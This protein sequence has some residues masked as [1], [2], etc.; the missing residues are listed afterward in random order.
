MHSLI[1]AKK[2][3]LFFFLFLFTIPLKAQVVINEV[4]V[5][6]GGPQGMLGTNDQTGWYYGAEYIEIFNNSCQPIDISG[7]ILANNVQPLIGNRSGGSFS[8]PNGTIIQPNSHLVLGTRNSSGDPNS[9]DFKT[10]NFTPL[11]T[12]PATGANNPWN[13]YQNI[14][15]PYSFINGSPPSRP[16]YWVLPNFEGWLALYNNNGVPQDA[17]YWTG[18]NDQS[19]ITN[20]SGNQYFTGRPTAPLSYTNVDPTLPSAREI[21]QSNPGIIRWLNR[22]QFI[23]GQSPQRNPD[24][25]NWVNT[26]LPSINH[27]T[28]GSNANC[29]GGTCITQALPA[30]P[31]VTTP[32]NYCQNAVA[33]AL[34]ATALPL[35][36]LNW[37]GTN[38]T[39]G[40]PSSTAPTP[41]TTSV[42]T[43]TYYVSQT[44]GGCESVRV[45]IVVNV[46]ASSSSV[47]SCGTSTT[48]SV[49]FNWTAATGATGY[50]VSYQVNT[51]TPVNVGA[52]GN[53]F[54]YTVNSLNSGDNVT[55]TVTPTG[56]VATC[57]TA[58]T[59][60]CA[61]LVNNA[62]GACATPTCPIVGV[63]S[64]ANLNFSAGSCNTWTPQATNTTLTNYYLVTSDSSGFL[65]IA[66]QATSTPG[67]IVRSAFIRPLATSCNI[68]TTISPSVTNA[69]GVASGFNPEWYGLTPNT[70]YV[71]VETVVL[72]ATCFL[73]SLCTNYYGCSTPSAPT[74][75]SITQPT[76]TTATG[77]FQITGYNAANT[78]T[79]NPGVVSISATGL[80]T[81]N[82]NTYTFTVTN[83]SGCTSP[84][85]ANIVVNAQPSTPSAPTVGLVTQPTCTTATGSF[86]ITGY[87]AANTY[88]FNPG[89]LSISATGLVTANANT[90][91][92]TVTN[93][94]GCTSPSSANI[95]VNAQPSTPSAPTVGLVT[96]P[97]CTTA[98]GSFQITGYNAA[99]TYTFN[100]GVLS[101]SATGLVTANTNTYTFT[102]TNASGCTSPSS[103]N[104]VV[105]AQPSTPSA[106]TV[107]AITQPTCTTATGS[108]QITAF[109]AANT[110]TFNPGVLS[111]SATGLVTANANTYTFTVTNASG[112]TSPSSANIVVNTQP[113]TPSA[114]TVGAITQPTCTTATGS[115]QITGFN[116]A[117]TY[118]FNPGVVSISSTGL[119]TANANTYTFTVTNASGCTSPSSSNIL[120]NAQPSPPSAPTIGSVTQP[121]CTTA[122]GSFQ[123][124]GFNASNTY[125]FNPGVVSISA[126][127][128]VTANANTYTF[129][130][131]NASGCTSSSSANI[132]VNTQPSTPSA[133]TVGSVTQPTCTTATGSFQITGFNATNTYTF[134]PGVVSISATG[135]VTA[136]ANNYTFTVTNASGCTSP[137]S[138]NIVVNTQPSTPSAPTV[139]AITQPTCIS[140]T[141]SFQITG[142]NSS[143]TYTFN[144]GVLS[145][146]ATGLVTA[147]ANTYTF[148]VTNAFGC[149][150]PSSA[151]IVVNPQP[152]LPIIT[153]PSN[154]VVCDENN[155]GESCL[156]DLTTKN[157]Q[158]ST[159]SGIQISY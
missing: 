115:F 83:V 18:T 69:N 123:I 94:S 87:N 46:T 88:T 99:N 154:Y 122:S 56:G 133:P 134:N 74:V 28:L 91:T 143:N 147:N 45:P 6:P 138:A 71:V 86:Q 119:V 63:S 59:F 107:G 112:C 111:I 40:T 39:G 85:S 149:T 53:V 30:P 118:T 80:V 96:Q 26:G 75:G 15:F 102:V 141:G 55:I 120:V 70:Q 101:I 76:C 44:I 37:Y 41:L 129:T 140:A 66:Q 126:T 117:N 156:F 60:S 137:S 135:L 62:C 67:C 52:I 95:V 54:T 128:L 113:S 57:F 10:E 35:A 2:Y 145:I 79:F 105:N 152:S 51:A 20:A 159:Q 68:A 29:N 100:P 9:I 43:T 92:F 157:S 77:S 89:V 146:S 132:V 49:I 114:P 11:T 58:S 106:P 64:Y 108:F 93:A 32:V 61:T 121:T 130:V 34:T 50:T 73:T 21:F 97:T 3:Y 82:A 155:D 103:A 27:L 109:N 47:I 31:T 125:T 124:T 24:G 65:G 38:A 22:S 5:N 25:G 90:Y 81:A 153:T 42:G 14:A 33:S 151:N 139:G 7:W 16:N 17:V 84:S 104:I 144:P 12:P 110:Y 72:S 36:T 116:A 150:S 1:L 23:Q 48:T 127:G 142:Y 158:I 19:F 136:N 148:I 8:F 98:T 131:T 13:R 4:M 78:Y